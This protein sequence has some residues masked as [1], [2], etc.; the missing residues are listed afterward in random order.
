MADGGTEL[1]NFKC[2]QCEKKNIKKEADIYCVE[3]QEY[4]CSPCTDLHKMFPL[5]STHQFIDKSSF[6]TVILQKAL[7]EKCEAHKTELLDMYCAD[8][9]DVACVTCI[10]IKHRKCQH[11]HSIPGDVDYLCKEID[12]DKTISELIRIKTK[13]E[14]AE[15]AKKLLIKELNVQKEKATESIRQFR[16]EIEEILDTFEKS[17]LKT[18]EEKY[19]NSKEKL[20]NEIKNLHRHID[21]LKLSSQKLTKSVGN[22]AQEF[23]AVKTSRKQIIEATEAEA[24]SVTKSSDVKVEFIA[25]STIKDVLKDF[26][27]FGL[28]AV[29]NTENLRDKMYIVERKKQ[30]NIKHVND[31][32]QCSVNGSCFID[33]ELLFLTDYVNNTL[34]LINLSSESIKDQLNLEAA[35]MKICQISTNDFAVSLTNQTV[36][37]VTIG[38]KVYT[39]KQLKLDHRCYGLAY[40]DNKLF[41]S[42]SGSALYIYD[43]NGTLLK[44]I[45][46]DGQGN[47]IF[48]ANRDISVSSDGNMIYV[49]NYNS[50]IVLDLDGNF[51]AT[52]TDPDVINPIGVCTDKRGNIFM[53]GWYESKI[54]QIN[55]KTS[56]ILGIF[57]KVLNSTS[58]A[59]H[60]KHNRLAVTIHN[61]DTVD[62]YDLLYIQ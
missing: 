52:I 33:N 10:A 16:K 15:R 26:K 62:V 54:V 3:C 29:S 23:V 1:V 42:D 20:G 47:E 12:A 37:F 11:I 31:L 7:P 58:C 56:K 13:I 38:N 5:M 2:V 19:K 8:H 40:K 34:K 21:E 25:D 44:K 49:A 24:Q 17:T 28:I 61:S 27:T 36:Q 55:E 46:T 41:I 6:N 35:P 50:L 9:D 48:N 45:T 51:K 59:F 57:G 53:F 22:K 30:V 32:R 4:Y 18:L 14:E 60:L 43:M 39:T